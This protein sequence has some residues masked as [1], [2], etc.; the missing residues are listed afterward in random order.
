MYRSVDDIIRERWVIRLTTISPITL[1]NA[2]ALIFQFHSAGGDQSLFDKLERMALD[3]GHNLAQ[4]IGIIVD[5]KLI[6][7]KP[8]PTATISRFEA[9]VQHLNAN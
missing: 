9:A 7:R 5:L 3:K 2:E 4:M 6:A 1:A 8:L